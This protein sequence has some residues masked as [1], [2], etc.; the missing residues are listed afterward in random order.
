M[1]GEN[2]A[3]ISWE[4][5]R[6]QLFTPEEILRSNFRVALIG[7]LVSA[8]KEK[9]VTQKILGEMSGIKQSNIARIEKGSANPTV[10]TVLRLLNSLGKTLKIVDIES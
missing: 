8:R 7:E 3:D 1:A 9:G 6:S 5:S 4:E 2:L 10:D